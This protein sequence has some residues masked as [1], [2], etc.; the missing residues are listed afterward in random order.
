MHQRIAIETAS[1]LVLPEETL[2]EGELLTLEDVA[3]NAA[4]LAGARRDDGI[5]TT[6]LELLLEGVLDLAGGLEAVGLLLLD[7]LGLLGLLLL[8][9]ALGLAAAAEGLA[10]VSLEP[11]AERSGVDLDDGG[12]GQGVGA[13]ELVVGGMVDDADDAGLLGDALRAPGVVAGVET[14]SAELAVAATGA[15]KMDALAA[16]TGI[17]GLATLLE[18]PIVMSDMTLEAIGLCI[19]LLAVVCALGTGGGA[20]VA[21]VSGDTAMC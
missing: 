9:G 21:R 8:L 6:G 3:V 10:V 13:D 16:N 7:R 5:Q 18:S 11:L 1:H 4:G 14:E 19:P 2:V 15:D 17:G 12:L 20:L